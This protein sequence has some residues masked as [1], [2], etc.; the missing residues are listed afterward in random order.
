MPQSSHTFCQ[1]QDNTL[2]AIALQIR[3]HKNNALG[4]EHLSL[5]RRFSRFAELNSNEAEK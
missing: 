1:R 5:M 2:S 4:L 3:D